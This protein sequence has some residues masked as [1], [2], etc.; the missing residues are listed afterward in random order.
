[1]Y[2]VAEIV[3]G[4]KKDNMGNL[5]DFV[6]LKVALQATDI[7]PVGLDMSVD[8]ISLRMGCSRNRGLVPQ[9]EAMH[10]TAVPTMH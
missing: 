5:T 10:A 2:F 7:L 3:V 8:Y 6:S 4:E 9:L 1:M